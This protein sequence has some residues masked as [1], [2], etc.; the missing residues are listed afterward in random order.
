MGLDIEVWRLYE[1]A[2]DCTAE[3]C[4][5]SDH[6][7]TWRHS[8]FPA[9]FKGLT[10]DHY[11]GMRVMR[12]PAGSYGGYSHWRD[13]LS[14]TF[15]GAGSDAVFDK[16]ENYKEKPF[17]ELINYSDCEG[18][19]GPKV[20][21]KLAQDFRTHYGAAHLAAIDQYQV[22]LYERFMVAFGLAASGCVRFC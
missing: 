16:P 18:C 7:T 20:C 13:W 9:H 5:S 15:L 19:I 14:R 8:E 4:E 2:K 6:V 1:P 10:E 12:F 21:M 22:I 11:T 3:T 17:E